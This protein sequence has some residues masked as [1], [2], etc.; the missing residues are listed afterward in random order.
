VLENWRDDKAGYCT[1]GR[2]SNEA[3][4]YEQTTAPHKEAIETFRNV[5]AY[6]RTAS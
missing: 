6:R 1:M 2:T 5:N 3:I 4:T